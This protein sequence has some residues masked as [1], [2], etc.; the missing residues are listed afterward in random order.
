MILLILVA[1]AHLYR[2]LLELPLIA[3]NYQVP[4]WASWIAVLFTLMMPGAAAFTH[5][6]FG[7][8][9]AILLGKGIFGGDGKSFLSPALLGV[10][11]VQVSFPGAAGTHPLWNGLA[12]FSGSDAVAIYH[13]G[14]EAA[15][16]FE[17]AEGHSLCAAAAPVTGCTDERAPE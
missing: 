7:M 14:G 16:A 12:G 11:I 2:A 13:R 1:L 4:I 5:V 3:G 10:A 6:A 9:C 8:S 15:P 17:D